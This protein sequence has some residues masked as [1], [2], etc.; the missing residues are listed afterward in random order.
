MYNSKKEA[1][2]D[3]CRD[4]EK[5]E[6]K[7]TIVEF[8]DKTAV[9]NIIS[10]L[11]CKPDK[12]IF[13]GDAGKKMEKSLNAYRRIAQNR[14]INVDF[15]CRSVD[16]NNLNSIVDAL[17]KLIEENGEC[18]FDLLGGE[19]LYLVALGMIYERYKDKVKL[20]KFNVSSGTLFNYEDCCNSRQKTD[21]SLT[22]D[23]AIELYGGR[24]IYKDDAAAIGSAYTY[25]WNF[26]DRDFVADIEAM[27][28]INLEN[29]QGWNMQMTCLNK[30]MNEYAEPDS[31]SLYVEI[32]KAKEEFGTD[33]FFQH[34]I[35]HKLFTKGM[36][37]SYRNTDEAF[38]LTFKNEAIKK[39][40][41]KAGQVLELYFMLN[42]M[43]TTDKKGRW[44][45]ND[46]KTGVCIDWDRDQ[47]K[48]GVDVVNEIDA[49]L[50]K[51]LV[52]VFVSCKNGKVAQDE[53]YKLSA[54]SD[55]FGGK[56]A[57]KVLVVSDIAITDDD[58]AA[59]IK[60]RC[61]DMGIQYIFE[62]ANLSEKEL[63]ERIATLWIKQN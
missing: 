9:E 38:S 41:T 32:E 62:T 42:A 13:I 48:E 45:Y 24:I 51:G 23:E 57:Q 31:L 25:E 46:F 55:F 11:L 36:L 56:Y 33:F 22:V 54:I 52:P 43:D 15:D 10:T 37:T 30:L 63:K 26:R 44:I 20:Q 4:K 39:C 17:S 8:Y 35:L 5:E 40:L 28:K 60:A 50:M 29:I 3:V 53:A 49:I 2:D 47:V 18:V 16:R 61:D 59:Y 14:N 34:H 19:E 27:W 7:M 12:V 6:K 21:L 1:A 58:K